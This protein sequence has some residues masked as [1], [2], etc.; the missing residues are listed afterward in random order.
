M[1]LSSSLTTS[2]VVPFGASS[3]PSASLRRGV[4]VGSSRWSVCVR[5]VLG[6]VV[7][8][9]FFSAGVS[10]A[11][12]LELPLQRQ[13]AGRPVVG[14]RRRAQAEPISRALPVALPSRMVM[15]FRGGG[16]SLPIASFAGS[17][18][19]LRLAFRRGSLVL[20]SEAPVANMAVNRTCAKSRAGR[21]PLRWASR[22]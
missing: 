21:L 6:R 9:S 13:A 16:G 20:V 4:A 2:S 8:G 3:K 10:L 18:C 11:E 22:D 14:L 12:R 7:F 19:A 1:H 15:A 5:P 17:R